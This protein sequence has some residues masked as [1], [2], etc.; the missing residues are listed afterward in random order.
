MILFMHLFII[1][2]Y[3]AM[4]FPTPSS[5]S[6]P[7]LP[8][9]PPFIPLDSRRNCKTKCFAARAASTS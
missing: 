1:L 3:L 9:S 8:S 2:T 5:Y 4:F 6:S 7:S